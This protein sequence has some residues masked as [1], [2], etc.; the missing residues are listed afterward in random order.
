[1]K[2]KNKT[3]KILLAFSIVLNLILGVILFCKIGGNDHND[4]IANTSDTFDMATLQSKAE[5][6]ARNSIC[7]TLFYPQ[8][9]DPVKTTI[10]SVFYNYLTDSEC[11]QAAEELIDL[12]GKYSSALSRYNDAI[13]HIK[14]HG[15][16]DLGTFHWGK[17]RDAAKVEM[18][19]LQEKIDRRQAIIKSRDTSMDGEFIGWQII[20]RYRASNNNGVVSF[21][22]V[23]FVMDRNMEKCYFR[24]SLEDK[25]SKSLTKIKETI[26]K[27][28]GI[29]SDL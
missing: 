2:M 4:K 16:T 15:M 23:L 6:F 10:D 28:L 11:V 3:Y 25:D 18:K 19:E 27:E 12:R 22:D 24:Y 29:F 7:E 1:M 9:Y 8:S 14:F 5:I 20:H 21:G 17:D 13:D 26:Q